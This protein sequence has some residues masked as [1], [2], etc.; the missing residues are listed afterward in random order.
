M[1]ERAIEKGWTEKKRLG[2]TRC[3]IE[4]GKEVF[5]FFL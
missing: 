1:T 4:L 5:F 2:S 3:D